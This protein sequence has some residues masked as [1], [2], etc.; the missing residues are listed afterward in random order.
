MTDIEK[1]KWDVYAKVAY[2][3]NTAHIPHSAMH[4]IDYNNHMVG[5][6]C[7]LLVEKKNAFQIEKIIKKVFESMGGCHRFIYWSWGFLG[8]HYVKKE[9]VRYTVEI[10]IAW[11]YSYRI[12]ELTNLTFLS[13]YSEAEKLCEFYIDDWNQYTKVFLL[14]FLSSDFSKFD[15]KRIEEIKGIATRISPPYHVLQDVMPQ[16]VFAC[17]SF[18]IPTL[19]KLREDF[20]LWR[21]FFKHPFSCLLV[22]YRV[23]YYALTRTLYIHKLFP[24]LVLVGTDD[25]FIEELT[26]KISGTFITKPVL[27]HCNSKIEYILKK[28][29]AYYFTIP[30]SLPVFITKDSYN[31]EPVTLSLDSEVDDII[32]D[33]FEKIF[34]KK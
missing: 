29:Q 23:V 14:R 2:E 8:L 16:W 20:S 9:N 21:Y 18:S 31:K 25:R 11:S 34:C 15:R 22:L 17:R 4:G 28:V 7:D 30:F 13:Y 19:K 5:R 33:L 32:D 1:Y 6:D 10:D 3:L 26:K 12:I 27:Y 24:T